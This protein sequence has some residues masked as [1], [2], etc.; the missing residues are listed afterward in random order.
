MLTAMKAY[1]LDPR[2]K[3]L[4]ACDERFGSQQAI[5]A[6]FGVSQSFVEKL[7][8]RRLE[9]R[10]IT[11]RPHTL[12]AGGRAVMRRRSSSC[13]VWST[14]N[15]MPRWQSCVSSCRPTEVPMSVCQ[16]CHELRSNWDFPEKN[17]FI[18]ASRTPCASSRRGRRPIVNRVTRRAPF[19]IHR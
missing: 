5:A 8:R 10:D 16:P 4:R 14:N 1:S 9:G 13:A 6:L 12:E 2:Q 11:P 3:I 7:L 15:L 17:R 19:E 18:P